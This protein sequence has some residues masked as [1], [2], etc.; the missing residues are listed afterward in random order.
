MEK[1]A[2]VKIKARA[3]R[4][5]PQAQVFDYLMNAII[6]GKLA[7]GTR[8]PTHE[9]I[10]AKFKTTRVTVH[11]ALS[12]LK[13]DGFVRTF[14]SKGSFVSERPPNLF[15]YGLMASSLITAGAN[16]SDP[17][18]HRTAVERAPSLLSLEGRRVSLYEDVRPD[19]FSRDRKRLAEDIRNHRLAGIICLDWKLF[20]TCGLGKLA[21]AAGIPV[22]SAK[23]AP[24]GVTVALDN[25]SFVARACERL[26]RL[27]KTRVAWLINVRQS[28]QIWETVEAESAR[29]KMTVRPEWRLMG[30]HHFP[31]V[32]RAPMTLLMG[33]PAAARPDALVIAD[34]SLAAEATAGLAEASSWISDPIPVIAHTNF[35][36]ATITAVPVIRLGYD[37]DAFLTACLTGLENLR[38]DTA[39]PTKYARTLTAIFEEERDAHPDH[40]GSDTRAP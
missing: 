29:H 18:F 28:P 4:S 14:R 23:P 35:P 30:D 26:A 12:K 22:A 38:A 5:N 16:T 19:T 39:R 34:E 24:E 20:E 8:L 17:S 7:S 33:L 27:G 11:K 2:D 40:S 6:S 37:V 1:E 36:S 21:A 13:Q 9:A 31:G 32:T 25:P 15:N 10:A 3:K